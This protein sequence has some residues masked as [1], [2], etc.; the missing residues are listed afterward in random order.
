MFKRVLLFLS[1]LFIVGYALVRVDYSFNTMVKNKPK[2]DIV[3]FEFN[4]GEDYKIGFMGKEYSSNQI[5]GSLENIK[6]K[7][8][9][10]VD[11]IENK[12]QKINDFGKKYLGSGY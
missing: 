10:V 9:Y 2:I 1:F 6:N 4:N 3:Y 7:I 5:R 11:Y 8:Y 12:S